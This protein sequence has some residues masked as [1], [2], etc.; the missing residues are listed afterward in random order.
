M[1]FR[2]IATSSVAR[3]ETRV[4]PIQIGGKNPSIKWKDTPF[5]LAS[6]DEWAGLVGQWIDEQSEKF[7]NANCAVIAKPYERLFIDEDDSTAF[8][9]GYEL[10]SG[11]D[12]PHTYSTSARTDRLQSHWLQTDATRKMGN[13]AQTKTFSVRQHNL[14]VLTEGSQH[15][16][17]IDIYKVVD[18]SPVIPMPDSLVAY[19]KS[20]SARPER[21]SNDALTSFVLTGTDE[22]KLAQL[23]AAY[24]DG[25]I[26][27]GSHDVTLTSIAGKLHHA[28]KMNAEMMLPILVDICE[29][30]CSGYGVDYVEM[31]QKIATSV[32]RYEVKVDPPIYSNGKLI[33]QGPLPTPVAA[34]PIPAIPVGEVVEGGIIGPEG[35]VYAPGAD[36][37]PAELQITRMDTVKKEKIYWLW[38]Y[39][40]PLGE[41]TTIAGDPDEGKGLISM[42]IAARV[43]RGESFYGA[44][45]VPAMSAS[46]V[47]FLSAEDDP[48]N[49]LAP[50]LEAAGADLSKV[51]HVASVI[52]KDGAGK[53]I[54]ER[55]AQLDSDMRLIEQYVEQHPEI[56]LVVVDPVSSYLGHANMVKEQEVR[57]VLSPLVKLARKRNLAVILIAHFNKKSDARSAIDRVGGAKAIVGLGRAAWTCMRE[58]KEVT[59]QNR[60]V[61]EDRRMFLK[62]KNNLAASKHGGL[63]YT[64]S[65]RQVMVE[66]EHGQEPADVP[67]IVWLDQTDATSQDTLI[68]GKPVGQGGKIDAAKTWLHS[69]LLAANGH[70]W[71]QEIVAAASKAGHRESTLKLGKKELGIEVGWVSRLPEPRQSH[72][73]LPGLKVVGSDGKLGTP[74][75]APEDELKPVKKRKA[76]NDVNLEKE[77]EAA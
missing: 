38:Q 40:I 27:H 60:L 48:S 35:I 12:F 4:L 62:L 64:I 14:Y 55:E 65:T 69:Y 29:R 2:E 63:I 1:S 52:A 37:R 9:D 67:Y 73:A 8:R 7:P 26:Q 24:P 50:R 66:G 54:S 25:S 32:G 18:D 42:Y 31:C 15:K 30:C 33:E 61:V 47:L 43:S 34:V 28:L 71:V 3:G 49:T 39:R 74:F 20:L 77:A 59:D 16:N 75:D 76:K 19:I 17:G 36:A 21:L 22:E 44:E 58:P 68:D 10:F 53:T 41:S 70:A 45:D 5:D 13:V 72:W 57:S 56:K 11:E 46:G 51:F 6:T 23:L